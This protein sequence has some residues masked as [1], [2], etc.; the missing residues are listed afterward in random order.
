MVLPINIPVSDEALLPTSDRLNSFISMFQE[1]GLPISLQKQPDPVP[2]P[3]ADPNQPPPPAPD[4]SSFSFKV[5]SEIEP[6]KIL[7]GGNDNGVRID[8][9]SVKLDKSRLIYAMEGTLY[10]KK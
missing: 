10:A 7:N 5:E 8:S 3:Q 9:F 1:L 4:W 6:L 2:P